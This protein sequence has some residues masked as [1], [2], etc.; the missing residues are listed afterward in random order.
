MSQGIATK[1]CVMCGESFSPEEVREWRET[2]EVFSSNPLFICP[3]CLDRFTRQDLEEQFRELMEAP[4]C[5]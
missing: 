4:L 2:G 5:S 1:T 3:D